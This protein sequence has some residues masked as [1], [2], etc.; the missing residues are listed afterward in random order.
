MDYSNEMVQILESETFKSWRSKL[1]DR[2]AVSKITARI[3]RLSNGHFGDCKYLRDSIRELRI[4]H[5]PGY[6]VYFALR[7][8]SLILL[9]AGGEKTT[10]DADIDRAIRLAESWRTE[11]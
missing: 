7:G 6:R 4:D 9:L 2:V 11:T 10:Q 1:K 3:K 5:G 8:D